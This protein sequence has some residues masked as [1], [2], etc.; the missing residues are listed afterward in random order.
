MIIRASTLPY[1]RVF[2]FNTL[3]P[4][5][6]MASASKCDKPRVLLKLVSR[7]RSQKVLELQFVSLAVGYVLL[8]A[9]PSCAETAD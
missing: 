7:W 5:L 8:S 2:H 3:D 9:R 6:R 4:V 1:Y